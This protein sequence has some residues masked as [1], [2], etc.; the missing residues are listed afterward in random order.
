ME[1]APTPSFEDAMT[2]GMNAVA[3]GI[4]RS[5][6]AF[7]VDELKGMLRTLAMAF[8]WRRRVEP[9]SS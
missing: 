3:D 1:D 7:V 4:T 6:D 8:G 5:I 9:S 2:A